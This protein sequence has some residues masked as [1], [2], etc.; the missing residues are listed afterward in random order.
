MRIAPVLV[1]QSGNQNPGGGVPIY[2]G[3]SVRRGQL[4]AVLLPDP[5]YTQSRKQIFR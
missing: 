1:L 4:L 2:L 3:R 5:T